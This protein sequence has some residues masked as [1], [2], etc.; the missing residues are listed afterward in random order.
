MAPVGEDGTPIETAIVSH[1]RNSHT[2]RPKIVG[3]G[4]YIK[5]Y[6]QMEGSLLVDFPGIFESKGIELDIAMH[7]AL[8]KLMISAK[9]VKVLVMVSA[10]SLTP[11]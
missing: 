11:D 7:L 2:L 5:E 6:S 9:S 10:L 1:E 8:Q 4:K 3:N